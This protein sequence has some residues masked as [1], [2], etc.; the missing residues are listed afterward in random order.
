MNED[1]WRSIDERFRRRPQAKASPVDATEFDHAIE[2]FAPKIDP[3]YREFVLRY[4][5]GLVGPSPI[6]GLRKAGFLGT[7]GGKSTAPEITTWFREKRWPGI[8]DW[9]VFSVD[10]GGNPIGFATDCSVWLS[11][12]TDFPQIIKLAQ[13]FEDY[14][15]KWCLKVMN[16]E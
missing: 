8:D 12:Q 4:G 3:D 14:L 11:D 6:Y 13:G 15:L 2:L 9:L 10:Q 16:V 7:I 5:G 1:T